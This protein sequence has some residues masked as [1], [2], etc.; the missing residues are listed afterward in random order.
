MDSFPP[1]HGR[2]QGVLTIGGERADVLADTYDTPLLVLDVR[3]V[4]ANIARLRAACDPHGVRISYAAKALVVTA[5]ARRIDRRGLGIDVCSLGELATAERAG[6][7]PERITLHGA[8]KSPLELQAALDGRVGRIIV[9]SI[10]E[11]GRLS[12][13]HSGG[14]NVDVVLR[15]NTGI[16]AH[17]HDFV[18][19]AGDDSKFG[20]A[21]HEEG[22]ALRLLAAMPALRLRGLHAHIGS[23]I[24]EPAPFAA[25]AQQLLEAMQR[26]RNAGAPVATLILGGGFGIPT[27]PNPADETLDL[28]AAIAGMVRSVREGATALNLPM[29]TL[30]IEPGRFIV[31]NAGTSIYRVMA[32][33]RYDLRT[34]VIIDGSMADNPRPALYGAK[35]HVVPV[36]QTPGK[37]HEVTLCGRSCENDELGTVLLPEALREGDLLAM[38][39]AGAYTYSMASNY[40]R[41]VRPAIVAVGDGA[42]HLYARRETLDDVLRCDVD[43]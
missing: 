28:D 18:R 12:R 5:L 17:T 20:I 7:A 32:I 16:E 29:P 23:Q 38:C 26:F 21:P 9:D 36:R 8:G 22:A 6:I 31:G 40:N 14:R 34:F 30:E 3:E 35:H 24:Y 19:T 39:S 43:A 2:D 1:G 15:L 37:L 13:M 25:N 42:P 11:L 4:D 27:H 10:D 33:K 41:F